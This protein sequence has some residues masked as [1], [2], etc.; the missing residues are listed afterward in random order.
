MPSSSSSSSSSFHLLTPGE[1]AEKE[2]RQRKKR[3]RKSFPTPHF[4]S[5]FLFFY[6]LLPATPGSNR[7]HF[8]CKSSHVILLFSL[9]SIHGLAVLLHSSSL[10]EFVPLQQ[11]R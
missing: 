4:P 8:A 10:M 6:L 5:S 11:Y 3:W 9:H 2:K 1:P 7:R